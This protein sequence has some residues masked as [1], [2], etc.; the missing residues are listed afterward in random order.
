MTKTEKP[1]LRAEGEAIQF[2]P[3]PSPF[4]LSEVEGRSDKRAGALDK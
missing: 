3:D 2:V 4:A 1:L